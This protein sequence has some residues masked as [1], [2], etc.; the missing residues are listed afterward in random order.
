MPQ[1]RHALVRDFDAAEEVMCFQA[2]LFIVWI[3]SRTR[4]SARSDDR[5]NDLVVHHGLPYSAIDY[6]QHIGRAGR[7]G[8]PAQ[9]VLIYGVVNNIGKEAL[10]AYLSALPVGDSL[11]PPT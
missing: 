10:A 8:Q 5:R 4:Y 11:S 9:A 2:G 1:W 6:A 3:L 7:A